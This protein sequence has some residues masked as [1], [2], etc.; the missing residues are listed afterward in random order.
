MAYSRR[1]GSETYVSG[2]EM[3]PRVGL[4]PTPN[5]LETS[6]LAVEL[7]EHGEEIYVGEIVE[8]LSFI[9]L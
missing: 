6:A 4:E 9:W 1:V 7:T 5:V 3:V 8:P 2:E